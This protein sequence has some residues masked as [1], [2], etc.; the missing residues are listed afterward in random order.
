MCAII[1]VIAA[2]GI[3]YQHYDEEKRD[4]QNCANGNIYRRYTE[5]QYSVIFSQISTIFTEK[6]EGGRI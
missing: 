1:G 4:M 6:K 3:T 5:N 2:F